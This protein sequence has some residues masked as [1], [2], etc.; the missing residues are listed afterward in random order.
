MAI[1]L[2]FSIAAGVLIFCVG[3]WLSLDI[4]ALAAAALLM[5][6]GLVTPEEGISGFGN[7]ATITVMAMF[8]LSAGIERT[9]AVQILNQLLQRWSQGGPS[10]QLFALG[11]IVGPITAFINNTAVVATF[12]PVVEKWCKQRG[13]SPSKMMLPLSYLTILGGM[14]TVIGTSTNVLASGLS[15]KLGYGEFQLFQFTGVGL[16]TFAIGLTYVVIFGPKLLPNRIRVNHDLIQDDYELKYY[17]SEIEIIPGSRIAGQTLAESCLR[18]SV[19]CPNQRFDLEILELIRNGLHFSHPLEDRLLAVGDVLAVKASQAD[20]LEIKMGRDI[21]IHSDRQFAAAEMTADKGLAEVLVPRNSNLIGSTLKELRF[22]QRYNLTVLA[23]RH[24][25]M[26]KRERLS[27]V[28]LEF[29]DVLLLQGPQPSL[30]GLQSDRNLLL[31]EQQDITVTRN[32]KAWIAVLILIGVVVLAAF[33]LVSILLSSIIGVILMVV[34]GCLKPNEIYSA[35]RW[36]VV[37]LLAGLIPLGIAMERSGATT[38]LATTLANLGGNL[39]GYW[40]LTIFF[41]VTSILTEIL[42]NNASVVLLLPVAA[43]VA[44]KVGLNPM[45]F[46]FA[47]TF[48][49]S[50]SF[51]TPIGYQTNTMVYGPGGYKFIDYIRIG[52][53]LNILMAVVTPPLI[54]LFYGL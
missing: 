13:T 32:H 26:V 37:F 38:L 36:D 7:S 35:V 53:P 24:H 51:M 1:I 2:T 6:F 45:A 28:T 9:G 23:M 15:K 12:I 40:L 42:S 47:I 18:R 34:T 16:I 8:I 46:I 43:Q 10:Q 27:D 17:L 44:E 19:K 22:R 39:S 20:L 49:A 41:V 3:E 52:L 33:N 21:D 30:L 48:A 54:I 4:V 14:I 25:G 50:N 29:G 11:M 31:L 5:L